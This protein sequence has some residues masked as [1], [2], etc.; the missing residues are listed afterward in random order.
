LA[1]KKTKLKTQIFKK[2]QSQL[3]KPSQKSHK[4]KF[5]FLK[6]KKQLTKLKQKK[7]TIL[8]LKK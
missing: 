8:K 6:R 5:N 3:K 7:Q 2:K 1:H 4:K